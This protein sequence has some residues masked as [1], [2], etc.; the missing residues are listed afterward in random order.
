M[1]DLIIGGAEENLKQQKCF[2]LLWQCLVVL[3]QPFVKPVAFPPAVQVH[4]T[5]LGSG[6]SLGILALPWAGEESSLWAEY[7]YLF[8]R[9][10]H[11][12]WRELF[13]LQVCGYKWLLLSLFSFSANK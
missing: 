6:N 4:P 2:K 13:V 5:D 7:R 10:Q 9:L 3:T 8:I 1:E 12:G 11:A